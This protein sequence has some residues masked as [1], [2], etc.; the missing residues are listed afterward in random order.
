MLQG[1]LNPGLISLTS[2]AGYPPMSFPDTLHRAAMIGI[3]LAAAATLP[4][5]ESKV[6]AESLVNFWLSPADT[7]PI[8]PVIYAA[9]GSIGEV[10]VWTRPAEGYRM[11]A[12]SLDLIAEQPG[13]VSFQSVDVLNPQVA[14]MPPRYRHQIVFDSMTGLEVAPNEIYGF[15]GYTFFENAIGLSNGSGI[16]PECGDCSSA[17]G[18]PSWHVATVT[19]QAGLS[20]GEVELFLS[21]GEQGVWQ[22]PGDAVEPDEPTNTDVVFGLPNDVV[23]HWA[24][25]GDGI[26]HRHEPQGIADA[27]VRIASADFN[28]DGNVDGEDFLTWQ[29]GFGNGST[30]AEGDADGNGTVGAVDLAVWRY[31]FGSTFDAISAGLI[32][33]EPTELAASLLLI[34]TLFYHRV[35]SR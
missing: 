22:S 34:G 3:L 35:R 17:S 28:Q 16:G 5:G 11:S 1:M 2:R 6:R 31:Q 30:L 15:L 33:P 8:V 32:V 9:P 23:N 19:F 25:M 29:Q 26:D 10:Q 24:V 14:A 20:T 12:F 18:A 7:G 27:I 4:L 13:I 21:I